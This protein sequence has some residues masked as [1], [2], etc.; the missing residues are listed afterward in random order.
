MTRK[1]Y[2]EISASNTE[3]SRWP[4]VF[5][6]ENFTAFNLVVRASSLHAHIESEVGRKGF[7]FYAA[8]PRQTLP[9]AK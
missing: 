3:F 5:L 4:F 7:V 9:T 8:T 1:T 2:L 6:I